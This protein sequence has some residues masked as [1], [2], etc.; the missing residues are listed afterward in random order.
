M[1]GIPLLL[2][3]SGYL[4]GAGQLLK[5]AGNIG[6]SLF[7]GTEFSV[8]AAI[9]LALPGSKPE[10]A[11]FRI[12][13]TSDE[14]REGWTY[15]EGT[16]IVDAAG[17][18]YEGDSPYIVLSLDGGQKDELNSFAPAVASAAVLQRFFQV[19]D[20]G[21]VAI[22]SVVQGLQ[23]A[24]DFKYRERALKLQAKLAQPDL[25]DETKKQLT[26]ELKATLA[27]IQSDA[28]KPK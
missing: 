11:G 12:I 18:K 17:K 28:L 23:F 3:Y 1:A 21:Q 19:P 9:N 25:D 22:D 16:G 5:L 24:S 27:N 2:P 4:L 26:S 8:T 7:D 13:S 10:P 6:H 15:A 20:G 14:L